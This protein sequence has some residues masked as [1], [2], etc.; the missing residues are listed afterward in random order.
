MP[1]RVARLCAPVAVLRALAALWVLALGCTV[2]PDADDRDDAAVRLRCDGGG[3]VCE[4]VCVDAERDNAHCGNCENVCR[5][6]STC[7]NG[8]CLDRCAPGTADCNFNASDGCETVPDRDPANCG[9]CGN[10][11]AEG[12]PCVGGVCRYQA[13][14]LAQRDCN[15]RPDDGCETDVRTS[16]LHCGA[17]GQRCAAGETCVAGRCGP[18]CATGTAD[19]NGHADDRCETPLTDDPSNCG[20]CGLRCRAG[21]VCALGR[22]ACPTGLSDCAGQCLDL[23]SD[24]QNCGACG[25]VCAT[26][27]RCVAGR[28]ACSDGRAACGSSCVDTDVDRANCGACGNACVGA[29]RCLRGRC[30]LLCD[31]QH[32]DCD[33]SPL[34]GCERDLQRDP[35][36][37]GACGYACAPG[38]V[39][40]DGVC[41]APCVTCGARCVSIED[42]DTNCGACGVVC[43]A[44]DRCA[45]G[46][47]K[48]APRLLAPS[49]TRVALGARPTLRWTH[50]TDVS[51]VLVE[52]CGDRACRRVLASE[53][54]RG[55][56]WRV[57]SALPRGTSYWRVTA[58]R[59]G[60]AVQTR[61]ATWPLRVETALDGDA[62]GLGTGRST[63]DINADGRADVLTYLT[64]GLTGRSAALYGHARDLDGMQQAIEGNSAVFLGDVNGDG[65]GDVAAWPDHRASNVYAGGADGLSPHRYVVGAVIPGSVSVGDLH[66]DG[67]EDVVALHHDGAGGMT[68]DVYPGSLAGL[69]E[70]PAQRLAVPMPPATDPV[71]ATPEDCGDVDGD[72]YADVAWHDHR[73]GSVWIA[74]GGPTGLAAF[75]R[76]WAWT[77]VSVSGVHLTNS[78]AV[79]DLDG[80][81][82][83]DF[84][85]VSQRVIWPPQVDVFIDRLSAHARGSATT[86]RVTMW[87]GYP[88]PYAMP[89]SYRTFA[90]GDVNG[91]GLADVMFHYSSE[92]TERLSGASGGARLFE[93]RRFTPN[94]G[95]IGPAGDLDGDGIDDLLMTYQRNPPYPAQFNAYYGPTVTPAS[96]ASLDEERLRAP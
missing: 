59:N 61:S 23:R 12:I 22:C 55:T 90:V 1:P 73:D 34:N 69:A 82:R 47:C 13:C 88:P 11:C 15:L 48:P 40:R 95:A 41:A 60:G 53:S 27:L 50:P 62:G 87:S 83:A 6:T 31:E 56:S 33:G 21:Q 72:G 92:W 54:V 80:D 66:G 81:G 9:A 76:A 20:A 49:P 79:G 17:C 71:P 7:V 42:D 93:V 38:R 19:C 89:I 4:G 65:F 91:D 84:A 39:C 44:G 36:H 85:N 43:R 86:T 96:F 51:A 26:N 28:C 45:S 78:I 67:F 32:G 57:P 70:V 10:R 75:V 64:R 30:T 74:W 29:Q 52:V 24:R 14:G 63:N 3:L 68:L 37:C 46:L 16:A 94:G 2:G 18:P 35:A 58:S 77:P 25:V 5:G 8:V